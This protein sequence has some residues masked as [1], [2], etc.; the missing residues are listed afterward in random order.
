MKQELILVLEDQINSH[1]H[2]E[3]TAEDTNFSRSM[4]TFT[5]HYLTQ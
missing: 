2:T 1:P 4:L 3:K 5:F